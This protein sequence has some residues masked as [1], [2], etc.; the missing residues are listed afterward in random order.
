MDLTASDYKKIASYY[1]I[2][3]SKNK[4]YK[5]IT[6]H[7]LASKLC[8]CIKAV[9]AGI[10]TN[11]RQVNK[12]DKGSDETRAVGICRKNI[13]QNRHIDF[14]RFKCKNKPKLMPFSGSLKAL[15]K[16]SKRVTFKRQKN[17]TRKTSK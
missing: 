8:R 15:K 13:F 14:N 17:R 9:D 4:T 7:V 3:K 1:Q 2:P 5:E 10:N 11:T 16:T 12:T 6:E